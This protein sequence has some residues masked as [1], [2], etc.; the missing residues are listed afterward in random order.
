VGPTCRCWVRTWAT[1]PSRGPPR[2]APRRP[3][4]GPAPS[5]HISPEL[6]HALPKTPL[7]FDAEL[8]PGLLRKLFEEP[9]V[10][11]WDAP[12][13]ELPTVRAVRDY[14][15]GKQGAPDRRGALLIARK[16]L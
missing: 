13:V 15:V 6:A 11:R 9:E 16:R 5:R 8:A 14:L 4:R 12:L 2:D 7:T 3:D 1:G 10:K